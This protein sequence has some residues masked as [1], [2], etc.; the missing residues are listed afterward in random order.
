MF[1]DESEGPAFHALS[2][3]DDACGLA[4]GP[5]TH[6]V[7]LLYA[8]IAF[9]FYH[10]SIACMHESKLNN[11]DK[12]PGTSHKI[13]VSY[14]FIKSFYYTFSFLFFFANTFI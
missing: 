11:R 9:H 4:A 13:V 2:A 10:L 8:T 12:C 14:L 1:A 7:L 3:V 6:T 5:Q